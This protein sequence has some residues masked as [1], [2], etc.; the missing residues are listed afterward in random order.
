MSI[1]NNLGTIIDR[2][3]NQ[4]KLA[5]LDRRVGVVRYNYD[6]LVNDIKNFSAGIQDVT[7]PGDVIIINMVNSFEFIVAYFGIIRSGRVAVPLNFKLPEYLQD[8]IY[9]DS[10]AVMTVTLEN[11]SSFLKPGCDYIADVEEDTPALMLYTSGSTAHPKGVIL[12]HKHK[13]FVKKK[14]AENPYISGRAI[15]LAG[16]MYHASGIRNTEIALTGGASLFLVPNFDAGV[17]AKAITENRPTTITAVP[18]IIS[19]I[20][21]DPEVLAKNNFDSIKIIVAAGAPVTELLYK[22]VAQYF[23]NAKLINRYGVTEI[24][25]GLF[26]D[27]PDGIDTPQGS[28]GYP[29]PGVEY[30]LINDVLH[31]KSPT[32]MLRYSNGVSAPLTDDGFYITNDI[33]RI[34]EQGFYYYIARADDMFTNGGNNVYPRQIEIVLESHPAIKECVVVGID[35]EIK[36]AKPYAMVSK[37]KDVT[38]QELKDHALNLLPATHCPK[39]IWIFDQ[40]PLNTVNKIDRKSIKAFIEES[41]KND[42]M[43]G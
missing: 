9:Q 30:K 38:E 27:H 13:W 12:S 5:I 42:S 20:V 23:P 4:T 22:Q 21:N 17:V 26:H 16:P 2:H 18:T 39:R 31:I 24:G 7:S 1:E 10:N 15:L 36:G 33:F 29:L 11:F 40:I 14:V 35:D 41:L 25:P 28:V 34:D 6:K 32:M 8:Y 19:K 43:L 3:E 37:N